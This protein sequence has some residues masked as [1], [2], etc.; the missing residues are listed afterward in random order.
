[1]TMFE[2]LWHEELS[3]PAFKLEPATIS[4]WQIPWRLRRPASTR[5]FWTTPCSLHV[6]TPE[7][8]S[9]DQSAMGVA[10]IQVSCTHSIVQVVVACYILEYPSLA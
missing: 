5:D 1:M 2:Q 10:I 4:G 7:F 9:N 6:T 3:Q 8:H